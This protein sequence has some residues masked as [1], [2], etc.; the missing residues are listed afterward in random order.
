MSLLQ[1]ITD[2]LSTL[3]RLCHFNLITRIVTNDSNNIGNTSFF[4]AD[5]KR[6]TPVVSDWPEISGN[7]YIED[8][9]PSKK[10]QIAR[11]HRNIETMLNQKKSFSDS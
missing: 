10:L 6:E 8:G 11:I 9:D 4:F 5:R 3:Y 1:Q 2:V 7:V